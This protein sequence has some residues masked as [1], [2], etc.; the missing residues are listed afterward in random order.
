MLEEAAFLTKQ[1]SPQSKAALDEMGFKNFDAL[2]SRYD[3]GPAEIK[4]FLGT[5]P[6]LTD[7]QPLTEYFLSLPQNDRPVDFSTLHGSVWRH[8][9]A[10]ATQPRGA[11]RGSAR[12]LPAYFTMR[13]RWASLSPT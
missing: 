9:I 13:M 12:R 5:G 1:A 8:V 7:D 6:I 11:D 4:T 10:A 2:L 3:A